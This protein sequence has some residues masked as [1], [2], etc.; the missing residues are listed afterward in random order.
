MFPNYERMSQCCL[1]PSSMWWLLASCDT[2]S[3]LAHTV[4]VLMAGLL[5][6]FLE[7]LAILT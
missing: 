2:W 6:Y 4:I 7:S 1:F 3:T 5:I